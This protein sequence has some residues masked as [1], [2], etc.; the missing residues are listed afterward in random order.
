VPH[1]SKY[2]IAA[3][4]TAGCPES[5]FDKPTSTSAVREVFVQRSSGTLLLE[6][7]GSSAH[8]AT[9]YDAL[10][11]H[12][13]KCP[14]ATSTLHGRV[15]AQSTHPINLGKF[16]EPVRAYTIS[17]EVGN[18]NVSGVVAYAKKGHVVFALAELSLERL[19]LPSF[20]ALLREALAKT[21]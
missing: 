8:P 6:R 2:Y 1:W 3:A 21:P 10:L 19:N 18:T 9:A 4:Q 15:T 17:A 7:L 13:T 5:T 16:A 11:A 12:M 14:K 20:R